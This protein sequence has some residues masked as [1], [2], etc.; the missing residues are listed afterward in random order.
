M[1]FPLFEIIFY[2]LLLISGVMLVS[3]Y[4]K[5]IFALSPAGISIGLCAVFISGSLLQK[6]IGRL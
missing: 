6:E 1:K 3:Y 2:Y 5:G 4:T